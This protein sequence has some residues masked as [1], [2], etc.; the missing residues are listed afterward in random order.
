MYIYRPEWHHV[1]GLPFSRATNLENTLCFVPGNS[2]ARDL[3]GCEE[4][5]GRGQ[6]LVNEKFLEKIPRH[7]EFQLKFRPR[8]RHR[9]S[10]KTFPPDEPRERYSGE[11]AIS[12]DTRRRQSLLGSVSSARSTRHVDQSNS[13]SM[14]CNSSDQRQPTSQFLLPWQFKRITSCPIHE[15][16]RFSSHLS[17]ISIS[18]NDGNASI[19]GNRIEF[20]W[21]SETFSSLRIEVF[22]F[23]NLTLITINQ[24]GSKQDGDDKRK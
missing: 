20:N 14:F 11:F 3:V 19:T 18:P 22:L 16:S 9:F 7:F 23:G 24:K 8:R 2:T 12:Q 21:W 15:T 5:G 17:R 4:R 1:I 10:D 13:L 6:K